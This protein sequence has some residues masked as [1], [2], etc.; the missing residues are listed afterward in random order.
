MVEGASACGTHCAEHPYLDHSKRI[1]RHQYFMTSKEL[2]VAWS[3][4]D[5]MEEYMYRLLE[6]Q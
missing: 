4:E 5:I 6:V 3:N 1:H 2:A